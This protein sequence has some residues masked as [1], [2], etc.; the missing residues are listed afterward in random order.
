MR[1][2]KRFMLLF[3]LTMSLFLFKGTDV[4]AAD[5]DNVSVN[6]PARIDIV[7]NEE[8][9]TFVSDLFLE[10]NSIIPV[11]IQSV[12]ISEFNEWRVVQMEQEI[13]VNTKQLSLWM[14]DTE[15]FTGN[16]PFYY[17]VAEHERCDFDLTV[18]R[19]AW[20]QE[21]AS[22]KALE[23]ELE[24]EIGTKEFALTLDSN[25]GNDASIT[26]AENG[27]IVSLPALTREG[28]K[29]VGWEDE[30]GILYEDKFIMPI[31]DTTLKAVWKE[32][33]AYALYISEDASLHFVKSYDTF[34]NGSIYNGK[35]VTDVYTGFEK[36]T[37]SSESQVPWYDQNEY[38]TTIVKEVVFEDAIQPISTAYWFCYMRDCEKFSLN[39][40]DTSNVTDMSYMFA[41]AGYNV[42][43]FQID[44]VSNFNVSQVGNMSYMFAYMAWNSS[45]L[46]MNLMNWN[47]LRVTN[48]SYMFAGT[49][50]NATTFSLGTLGI[51]RVS[52]VTNMD[53]MFNKTGYWANWYM[54]L[55]DWDVSKVTTHVN[56]NQGVSSKVL[57]PRW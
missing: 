16:N 35:M 4:K 36:E 14:G 3:V 18:K 2:I 9:T 11:K 32:P 50:Y 1:K 17:E 7:F 25:D 47:V 31:G 6:V 38:Q 8:G 55:R 22:E 40:L 33:V 26:Y 34:E 57:A 10:N 37:Y 45:S 41:W 54:Y 27:S 44:G 29:F 24:Y 42:S 52:N 13:L 5:I 46:V 51:W 28:Y 19:G 49:G 39:N 56:F 48:M 12:N 43:T 21:I 15:L 20:T 23:I 30:K 53:A